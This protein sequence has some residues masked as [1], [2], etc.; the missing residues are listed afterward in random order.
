[1]TIDVQARSYGKVEQALLLATRVLATTF[2]TALAGAIENWGYERFFAP[3][4]YAA[5][6]PLVRAVGALAITFP[7]ILVGLL[8]L[9]LPAAYV[10]RRLRTETAISYAATGAVAG[11]LWGYLIGFQTT[12]GFGVS[13]FY[14]CTCARIWWWLRPRD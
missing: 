1:M 14:G 5:G 7:F 13:A 11:V 8:I 4:L 10:L 9:G 3:D 6:P 12:Y 2:L